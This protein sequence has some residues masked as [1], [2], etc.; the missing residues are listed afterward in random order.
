MQEMLFRIMTVLFVFLPALIT[1]LLCTKDKN[2]VLIRILYGEKPS[3]VFWSS[4]APYTGLV[5]L[6]GMLALLL[7]QA[8]GYLNGWN[9]AGIVVV[10]IL[11]AGISIGLLCKTKLVTL[12]Q[13]REG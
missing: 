2:E 13:S 5:I 12:Y 8:M 6:Y 4:W 10:S 9:I 1:F 11:A 7:S 3:R